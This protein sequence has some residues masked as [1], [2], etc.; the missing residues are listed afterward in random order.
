MMLLCEKFIW[1]AFSHL[2]VLNSTELSHE[3]V[4]ILHIDTFN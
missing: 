3:I 1:L 2:K 4:D